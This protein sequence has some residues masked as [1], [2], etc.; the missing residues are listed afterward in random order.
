MSGPLESPWL[1]R[2][3]RARPPGLM[4]GPTVPQCPPVSHQDSA[5]LCGAAC[6]ATPRT[7]HLSLTSLPYSRRRYPPLPCLRP[8]LRRLRPSRLPLRPSLP[9]C[10]RLPPCLR[11][12]LIPRQPLRRRLPAPPHLTVRPHLPVRLPPGPR[13]RPPLRS[14]THRPGRSQRSRRRLALSSP[15][16]SGSSSYWQRFGSAHGCFAAVPSINS[17]L[18]RLPRLPIPPRSPRNPRPRRRQRRL[19]RRRQRRLAG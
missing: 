19:P 12:P 17:P 16:S 3:R 9:P 8:P 5:T 2:S 13:P 1:R 18:Q 7:A 6:D 10:P 4:N 14:G 11:P 15:A